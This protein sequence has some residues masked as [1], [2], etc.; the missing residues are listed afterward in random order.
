[1]KLGPPFRIGS[2][3]L[4]NWKAESSSSPAPF[5]I[6]NLGGSLDEFE[7]FSRALSAAEVLELYREGKPQPES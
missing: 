4:G 1:M 7:L 3:E 6:R 5:L 2:A